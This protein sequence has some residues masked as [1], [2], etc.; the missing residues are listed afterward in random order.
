M[1]IPTE[2]PWRG[3]IWMAIGVLPEERVNRIAKVIALCVRE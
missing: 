2:P 3:E 1:T